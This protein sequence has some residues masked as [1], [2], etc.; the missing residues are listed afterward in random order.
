MSSPASEPVVALAQRPLPELGP[1]GE[2]DVAAPP[3]PPEIERGWLAVLLPGLSAVGMLGF[4]LLSPNVLVVALVGGFAVLSTLGAVA[5]SRHQRRRRERSWEVRGEH[6][7]AHLTAC[8]ESLRDAASRQRAHALAVHPAPGSAAAAAQ[9]GAAWERRASDDHRLLVRLGLGRAPA[10]RAPRRAG[11]AAEA[12]ADPVLAELAADVLTRYGSVDGV[13][14]S[15]DLTRTPAAVLLGDHLPLLRALIVSLTRAHGRESVRI[16]ALAPPAELAWM[17]LLPHAGCLATDRES[18]AAG[19]RAQLGTPGDDRVQAHHVIILAAHGDADRRTWHA[20]A[21]LLERR[22][23]AGV[24]VLGLLPSGS[25]A[26]PEAAIVISADMEGGLL[27]QRSRESRTRTAV[28]LPDAMSY[29]AAMRYAQTARRCLAAT[30]PASPPSASLRL[31]SLLADARRHR[32]L[33][34]IGVDDEGT[35]ATI[36][37]REAAHDGDGPHGLIVGATGSGKSELLRTLLMAA[38]H[39]NR[40]QELTFLMVD[41]KGGAALAKLAALPHTVGLLTNLTAD[42]HGVDRLCAALRAEVRRRQSI[43]QRAHVDDIESYARACSPGSAP[44]P[45]PRLLVVVDEYAELIEQSPDVL[46]ILTSVARLGRSLGIHLLLCSQRLDDGR[47][48]GLEAHLRY[49]VCLRTFTA[50]ESIAVL[51]SAVAAG[52]PPAPGWGYLSRDGELTRLRVALVDDPS[53]AVATMTRLDTEGAR[54]VCLPPLPET[55]SLDRLPTAPSRPAGPCAA[56]GLCDRPDLGQQPSLTYDL[57]SSGHLAVVGAPCSGRSTLLTTLV[58]ALAV[59]VPVRELAIHVVS[60]AGGPLAAVAGLPHVGTVAASHELASRVIRTVAESVVERRAPQGG[61]GPRTLLVIDDLGALLAADDGLAP[62]LSV[63]AATG[64]SV[65]VTLA[66]SCARWAELRGG[67]REAMASRFELACHDPADSMLPQIARTFP[68]RPAGRVITGD[69][70][71]AQIALP[72]TDGIAQTRGLAGALADL[73]ASVAR[74]GGPATQPIQL[75]PSRVPADSLPRASG[76]DAV[77]LGLSGA[78]ARP[79]EVGL[80]PGRHLLVL[81]NAGSGRSGL[82]RAVARSLPERGARTWLIDPR[83]SLADVAGSAFRRASSADEVAA[84]I[85]ELDAACRVRSDATAR[86]VLVIDDQE[87][88]AG[89]GAAGGVL[90]PLLDLLPFASDIGLSMVIARRLSGYAR[91]AYEPF[92]AGFLD[93]CDT[94][95]VLSGDPSEGPVIGGVRPRRLPPGRGQLVVRGEPAGEVQVA[96]LEQDEGAGG[97]ERNDRP[98]G[99]GGRLAQGLDGRGGM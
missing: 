57:T 37:L 61:C 87:L 98:P 66:V 38:A 16:H 6:Y 42:L 63:I 90:M 9:M 14:L 20:L 40:P 81:G 79:V 36:D 99:P 43:L 30:A 18:L 67:I 39:Q 50:S 69:G 3:V 85:L 45:L 88:V 78:Y 46:D 1:A 82:L 7:R 48:R 91:G 74:R 51:G 71:W 31:D 59:A 95:V 13:A 34:P 26:P 83:R 32:L 58:A 44:A 41:F 56:I 22:P 77:A 53:A 64:Q 15:L 75:L 60:P 24:S 33:L 49:R 73:V 72:R 96:C 35:V 84:L 86:D 97:A 27:V 70:H 17:R 11:G 19:V 28:A 4:A 10:L 8:V 93:L 23:S 21:A 54:P 52:L 12:G 80:A 29:A 92:F 2:V 76:P 94:G 89:R 47:L 62:A 68:R 25:P 55:L 65:G 5:A